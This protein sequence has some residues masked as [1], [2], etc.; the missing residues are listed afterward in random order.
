M[1]QKFE[2]EIIWKLENGRHSNGIATA[3]RGLFN[4]CVIRQ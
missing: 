2:N 3:K 4:N 1:N